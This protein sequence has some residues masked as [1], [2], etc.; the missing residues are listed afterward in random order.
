MAATVTAP[1]NANPL[2]VDLLARLRV[3][4]RIADV[5]ALL[6]GQDLVPRLTRLDIGIAKPAVVVDE[7]G[8]RQLRDEV[9]CKRVEVHLFQRRE[10]M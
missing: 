8:H 2:P 10:S 9:L 7:T 3:R 5:V 1:P 6:V 4:D